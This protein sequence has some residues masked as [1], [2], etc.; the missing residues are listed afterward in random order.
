MEIIKD[1]KQIAYRASLQVERDTETQEL[2]VFCEDL[3]VKA[4]NRT[5]RK[6]KPLTPQ[7]TNELKVK[8]FAV[9]RPHLEL[10]YGPWWRRS[11]VAIQDRVVNATADEIIALIQLSEENVL[12]PIQYYAP[13][14]IEFYFQ[15]A[16]REIQP[17]Q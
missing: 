2:A 11:G 6:E 1:P 4:K 13:M 10:Q 16:Q 5:S 3:R 17:K 15:Q 9:A 14:V 7:E 8:I 12:T